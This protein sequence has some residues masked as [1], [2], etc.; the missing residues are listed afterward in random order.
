MEKQKRKKTLANISELQAYIDDVIE[1]N[2]YDLRKIKIIIQ[3]T[4]L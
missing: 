2:F 4:T 1:T 3:T